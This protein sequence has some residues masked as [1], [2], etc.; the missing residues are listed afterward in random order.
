[1]L[2]L[3]ISAQRKLNEIEDNEDKKRIW[4]KDILADPHSGGLRFGPASLGLKDFG[5][6]KGTGKEKKKKKK[7]LRAIDFSRCEPLLDLENPHWIY[8]FKAFSRV[9]KDHDEFGGWE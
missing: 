4:S 5:G 1:M 2:T 7:H 6:R 8:I 9:H 3:W